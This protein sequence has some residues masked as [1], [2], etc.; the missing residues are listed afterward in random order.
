MINVNSKILVI[1]DELEI[2]NAISRFL[3][4][5]GFEVIL[6]G[7][8]KEGREKVSGEKPDLVFLDVNLPDGNGLEELEYLNKNGHNSK[9]VV[10]SAFDHSEARQ[11]AMSLGA[12]DFLSKPFSIKQLNLIVQQYA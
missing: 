2:R 8:L 1:D 12:K 5:K 7:T 3:V 4:K 9:F 10:M 6:A 11:K